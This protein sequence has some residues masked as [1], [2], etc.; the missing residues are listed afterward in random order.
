MSKFSTQHY[1]AIAHDIREEFSNTLTD[2]FLTKKERHTACG[3]LTT[4][5]VR[6]A[7]RFEEDNERFDPVKFLNACS[8]DEAL[9]PL[10]ELWT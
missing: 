1:N 9:Y 5:A 6:L 4:L 8:P 10:G 2:D 7:K 3:V